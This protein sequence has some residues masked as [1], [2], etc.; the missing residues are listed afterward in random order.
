[1]LRNGDG[2]VVMLRADMD[3]LPVTEATGLPYASKIEGVS[4][5]CG[6]DLITAAAVW[7]S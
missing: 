6:H 1:M 3:A 4:H 2:P 7:L 5:V